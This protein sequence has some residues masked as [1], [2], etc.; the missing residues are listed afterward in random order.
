MPPRLPSAACQW[1]QVADCAS[2]SAST[3][4]SSLILPSS[5]SIIPCAA[6]R[7]AA[8]PSTSPSRK[9]QQQSRSFSATAAAETR[10]RRFF[11]HWIK[12]HKPVLR[13][14]QGQHDKPEPAYIPPGFGRENR[15]TPFPL[16]PHF[17]SYPVLSEELRE[18]IW[19]RVML[20]G[21]PMLSVSAELG[22]DVRRVAA[23]V[24]LKEVE[25]D[26][27]KKNKPLARPYAK[28]IM[29][30]LPQTFSGKKHEPFNE[31]PVHTFT[32][33]Q[34]FVPTSES[35]RFTRA[36]AAAAFNRSML[37]ADARIPHKEL[38]EME[39][40]V[41]FEGV[42]P[43]EAQG[44]FRAAAANKERALAESKAK[45]AE[46]ER[47]R[48]TVVKSSRKVEFRFKDYNVDTV[49]KQGR[50]RHG[51]GWRYGAMFL[52]RKKSQIKIPTEVS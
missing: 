6:T 51:V 18:E 44:A 38:V 4:A 21:E 10:L 8:A 17:Q 14:P 46:R 49:G 33:Q 13:E 2:F 45:A 20:E 16:N 31:I 47:E 19:Q 39:R 35:R 22:V 50:S 34:L 32:T 26:W 24:R 52:D 40:L 27:V 48:T 28:A 25:W 36:D 1:R 43:V 42:A 41:A 29:S 15:R 7:P 9:Q 37:P 30:M 3:P 11:W 12:R 23:V 5:T